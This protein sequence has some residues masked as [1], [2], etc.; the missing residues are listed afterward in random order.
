MSPVEI[1]K[2]LYLDSLAVCERVP[3]QAG[4]NN[5]PVV[6]RVRIMGNPETNQNR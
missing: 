5:P 4:E 6:A 3:M 1:A 2:A